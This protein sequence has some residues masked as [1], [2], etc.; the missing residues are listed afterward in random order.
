[1]R[2]FSYL[3]VVATGLALAAC[4]AKTEH[5]AAEERS[6]PDV[7]PSA[8]PGVAFNYRYAFA[9]DA[10]GI[11]PI[12]EKHAAACEALGI[13]RCRITG[14]SFRRSGSDSVYAE[15]E[16]AIQPDLARRFG[17]DASA[18]VEA[19]KG[20]VSTVEIGTRNVSD[21][22]AEG[23]RSVQAARQDRERLEA[24][25]R[26]T[27][28]RGRSDIEQQVTNARQQ[29]N[30]ASARVNAAQAAL[31]LTPMQFEYSTAGFVPGFSLQKTAAGAFASAL[32]V[33]DALFA[34]FVTL[35][36][37]A[38]PLGVLALAWSHVWKWLIGLWRQFSAKPAPAEE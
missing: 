12:Q 1:M 10:S 14:L 20:T 21:T 19:S 38:I 26:Q 32:W 29:E 24:A 16:L 15:L 33:L 18:L 9:L 35:A 8:A 13:Q 31:A 3:S 11:A 23:T 22:I 27:N 36:S 28:G 2:S 34:L 5:E 30:H 25:A 37:I 7:S 4:G 6:T 17:R